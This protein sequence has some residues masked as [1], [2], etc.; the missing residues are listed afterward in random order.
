MPCFLNISCKPAISQCLRYAAVTASFCSHNDDL[1]WANRRLICDQ[2]LSLLQSSRDDTEWSCGWH[3]WWER[4]TGDITHQLWIFPPVSA[5]QTT[6]LGLGCPD[7]REWWLH[8]WTLGWQ[9]GDIVGKLMPGTRH[10]W[11][12]PISCGCF[13]LSTDCSSVE[14]NEVSQPFSSRNGISAWKRLQGRG[15]DPVCH[16]EL[17]AA[18]ANDKICSSFWP[19]FCITSGSV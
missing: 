6:C 12:W 17:S 10:S 9:C 13:V 19:M 18:T 3:L 2:H 1:H 5:F 8:S 15:Y 4:V 11:R 7:F 14:D 16:K